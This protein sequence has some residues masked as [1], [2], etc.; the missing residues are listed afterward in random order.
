MLGN[1]LNAVAWLANELPRRGV[2]LVQGDRISTGVTTDIYFAKAGD[3]IKADF[4]TLGSLEISF[5]HNE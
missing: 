2:R 3:R 5:E 1:P 4:G